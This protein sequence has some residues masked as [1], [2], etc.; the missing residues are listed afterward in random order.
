MDKK[1]LLDEIEARFGVRPKYMGAPSFAYQINV[2]TKVFTINRKGNIEDSN[3]AEI[4]PRE[5]LSLGKEFAT[6]Q[7]AMPDG[8]KEDLED[9]EIYEQEITADRVE[10]VLPMGGHTGSTLKNLVN[11]VASKQNLIQQA[12]GLKTE[13]M[14]AVF[15]RAINEKVIVTVEDFEA[16]VFE[17]GTEKCSGIAFDF[18]SGTITFKFYKGELHPDKLKAYT[19]FVALI[20]KN[21]QSLKY[22]SMKPC[23]TDN[24]K[25]SFRTWLLR[26]SL[27]GDEYKTTRKILLANLEGNGAYRKGGKQDEQG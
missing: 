10:V 6:M 7:N 25:Y 23:A 26:L 14:D 24:P 19:D 17:I 5:L 15:T 18:E 4:E 20:N 1:E 21:A 8:V 27:I 12:F 13:I 2:G 3:G 9:E 16:A 11:M 22:A